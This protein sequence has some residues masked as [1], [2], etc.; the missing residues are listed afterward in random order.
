MRLIFLNNLT[1]SN[2]AM[3]LIG[4]NGVIRFKND[5]AKKNNFENKSNWKIAYNEEEKPIQNIFLIKAKQKE[6]P[7]TFVLKLING[8]WCINA[9]SVL[10]TLNIITPKKCEFTTFKEKNMEGFKIILS[11]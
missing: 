9:K 11:L 7:L 4:K 3:I 6:I 2:K 1:V 8:F 5:T 10:D